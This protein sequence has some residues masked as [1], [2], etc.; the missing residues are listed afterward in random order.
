MWSHGKQIFSRCPAESVSNSTFTSD[1]GNDDDAAAAAA[2]GA[3]ACAHTRPTGNTLP[4]A[5]APST[6]PAL[7]GQE[8]APRDPPLLVLQSLAA[9]AHRMIRF[10]RLGRLK[11]AARFHDTFLSSQPIGLGS[12]RQASQ[13]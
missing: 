6:T 12:S 9:L 2:S 8:I 11:F 7:G 10:R 3:F 1:S 5:L 4:I 13:H